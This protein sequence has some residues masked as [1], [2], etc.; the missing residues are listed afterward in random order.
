MFSI[1]MCYPTHV[2]IPS[3][4]VCPKRRTGETTSQYQRIAQYYLTHKINVPRIIIYLVPGRQSHHV[5]VCFR[6][7]LRPETKGSLN[8]FVTAT[9]AIHSTMCI[10]KTTSTGDP[11]NSKWDQILLVKIGIPRSLIR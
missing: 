10:M 3:T 4:R 1:F 2:R 8:Y 6:V 7:P 11:I 5:Y 9:L